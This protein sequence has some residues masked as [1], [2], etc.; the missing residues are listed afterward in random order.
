MNDNMQIFS[1]YNLTNKGEKDIKC[2][3]LLNMSCRKGVF[4]KKVIFIVI[5]TAFMVSGTAYAKEISLD[6]AGTYATEPASGFGATLGRGMGGDVG[7]TLFS[8]GSGTR[9]DNYRKN[10]KFRADIHYY[11][12]DDTVAGVDIEYNRIPLFVGGRYFFPVSSM[13][14]AG[15]EVFGEAGLEVSLDEEEAVVAGQRVSND[16]TKGGVSIGGGIRYNFT[17][18]VFGGISGRHHIIS[19][20]YTTLDFLIGFYI[21]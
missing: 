19:N 15:W 10:I 12:W 17:D 11:T 6:F 3:K 20:D 5:L 18:K 1:K 16:D 2:M 9:A 21:R 7:W 13:N 14:K 4:M 8:K